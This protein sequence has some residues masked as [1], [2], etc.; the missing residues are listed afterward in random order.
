MWWHPAHKRE[1]VGLLF[2]PT[3][4]NHGV[5]LP[6]GWS[7]LKG[8]HKKSNGDTFMRLFSLNRVKEAPFV[9]LTSKF[10]YYDYI[11]WTS[12]LGL[13]IDGV[14]SWSCYIESIIISPAIIGY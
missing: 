13:S 6:N 10:R 7:V 3:D 9:G 14:G 5:C 11:D 8:L 12:G 4:R 1:R 2:L